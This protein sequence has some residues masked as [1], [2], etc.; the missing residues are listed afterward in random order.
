MPVHRIP[1]PEGFEQLV[2][3][4]EDDHA[5]TTEAIS[6]IIT[7][8]A[9][10]FSLA[11]A[12]WT[13][14]VGAGIATGSAALNFTAAAVTLIIGGLDLVYSGHFKTSRR[15][16]RRHEQVINA[17]YK[18]ISR[19]NKPY[20]HD[21]LAR[22]LATTELGQTSTFRN[23]RPKDLWKFRD[24]RTYVFLALAVAALAFGSLAVAR[25]D[26]PNDDS[27]CVQTASDTVIRLD[28]ATE[29]PVSGN[30]E[31]STACK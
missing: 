15:Q 14:A 3:M 22:A 25:S 19:G 20:D 6:R 12:L 2:G 4:V 7:M 26:N 23:T 9:G 24:L 10:L 29:T 27:V 16:A 30:A 28:S 21:V 5:R 1:L 31:S 11:G 18:R 8:R 17:N 13:A